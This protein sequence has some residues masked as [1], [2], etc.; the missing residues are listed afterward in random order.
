MVAMKGR[1]GGLS[2]PSKNDRIKRLE[3]DLRE[4]RHLNRSR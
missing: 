3:R 1:Y 2:L 4:A